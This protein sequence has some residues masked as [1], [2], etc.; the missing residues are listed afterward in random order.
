M[1]TDLNV[2]ST[3]S[4]DD[5]KMS[6]RYVTFPGRSGGF[7]NDRSALYSDQWKFHEKSIGSKPDGLRR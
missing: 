5:L 3:R 7:D 6:C 1:L 2:K 4:L